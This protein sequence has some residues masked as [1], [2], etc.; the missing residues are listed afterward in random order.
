MTPEKFSEPISDVFC[1]FVVF[2]VA[3][4]R[5]FL[6]T[7]GAS[8]SLAG[9]ADLN[10]RL[11]LAFDLTESFL[12]LFLPFGLFLLGPLTL[13]FVTFGTFGATIES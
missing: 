3:S 4:L 11:C 6:E 5:L 10:L 7:F 2:G 1:V 9:H 12:H 13:H 8:F